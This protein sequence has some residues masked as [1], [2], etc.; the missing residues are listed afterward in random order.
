MTPVRFDPVDHR[1]YVGDE[2]WPHVTGLL[3]S[4]GL[5]DDTYY[6]EESAVRGQ[7]VHR[8]CTDYDLGV[9]D[10]T[11]LSRDIRPYVEAYIDAMLV[12][13]H[14]WDAIEEVAAHPVHRFVGRPDR[15]GRVFGMRG[16]LEIKSTVQAERAHEVQ[17]S[18]QGILVSHDDPLPLRE[19]K[20]W[21]LYVRPNGK[22]KLVPHENKRDYDDA[23]RRLA[24]GTHRRQR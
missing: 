15:V 5:V 24:A 19:W 14:E 2:E 9:L 20:R 21:A 3:K 4:W 10:V 18:L 16:V 12:V 6:T 13:P 1:Y 17:T 23:L 7:M 8:A 22:W 11:G